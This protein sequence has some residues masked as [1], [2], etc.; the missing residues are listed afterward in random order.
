MAAWRVAH[1]IYEATCS[2]QTQAVIKR[3]QEQCPTD[4]PVRPQSSLASKLDWECLHPRFVKLFFVCSANRSYKKYLTKVQARLDEVHQESDAL[5]YASEEWHKRNELSRIH[6]AARILPSLEALLTE[7]RT[8][9]L[10]KPPILSVKRPR[11]PTEHNE[12]LSDLIATTC[13]DHSSHNN[14]LLRR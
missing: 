14:R 6:Q 11:E 4:R 8:F 12:R 2:D 3:Y 10:P 1:G 7:E 5:N 9:S 13:C